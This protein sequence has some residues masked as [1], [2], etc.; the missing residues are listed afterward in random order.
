MNGTKCSFT[1]SHISVLIVGSRGVSRWSLGLLDVQQ[2]PCSPAAPKPGPSLHI[3]VSHPIKLRP[4]WRPS[5]RSSAARCLQL[6]GSRRFSVGPWAG[7]GKAQAQRQP[8][9]QPRASPQPVLATSRVFAGSAWVSPPPRYLLCSRCHVT[10]R[11]PRPALIN[12]E[13][14][15]VSLLHPARGGCSQVL[16]GFGGSFLPTQL[17]ADT[18]KDEP[19]WCRQVTIEKAGVKASPWLLVTTS[20]AQYS[21]NY[22]CMVVSTCTLQSS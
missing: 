15:R 19:H 9:P 17:R 14:P 16:A 3:S 7:V 2:R 22:V 8:C 5:L 21:W 1:E 6:H 20:S 11:P 10:L 4:F 13:Y 12:R 18:K